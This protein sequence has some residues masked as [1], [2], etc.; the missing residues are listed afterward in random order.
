M[1]RS[2]SDHRSHFQFGNRSFLIPFC[3]TLHTDPSSPS[4]DFPSH[5][6]SSINSESLPSRRPPTFIWS[7]SVPPSIP[8]TPTRLPSSEEKLNIVSGLLLYPEGDLS[9][10]LDSLRLTT[11][12]SDIPIVPASKEPSAI[13][14]ICQ[15]AGPGGPMA[16]CSICN[17]WSHLGCYSLSNSQVPELFLCLFCQA[18]IIQ[19]IKRKVVIS[20]REIREEFNRVL[21]VFRPVDNLARS[22]LIGELAKL[23][24]QVERMEAIAQFEQFLTE[25][26]MS[27]GI[28]REIYGKIQ[29]ILTSV[30]FERRLEEGMENDDWEEPQNSVPQAQDDEED[31][32]DYSSNTIDTS[33]G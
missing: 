33:S 15:Y 2:K 11:R 16:M 12:Y 8:Y 6:Q 13:H 28:I 32:N 10:N 4:S 14:C 1:T 18:K 19:S 31:E 29:R 23:N 24:G 30:V 26:K 27:W 22:S 21:E 5:S 17:C 3:S 20:V 7:P 25:A 9:R